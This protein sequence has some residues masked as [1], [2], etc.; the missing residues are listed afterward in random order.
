MRMAE[1]APRKPAA[2]L[3]TREAVRLSAAAL[4]AVQFHHGSLLQFD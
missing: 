2:E 4:R 3:Y 1:L